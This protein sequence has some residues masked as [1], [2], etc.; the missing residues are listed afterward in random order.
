MNKYV[1]ENELKNGDELILTDSFRYST[2]KGEIS[3]LKPCKGTMQTFEIYCI[4]G[5]LFDDVERYNTLEEAE[6]RIN[7]LLNKY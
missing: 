7:E 2:E 6:T 5:C 4:K 1:F 3:L